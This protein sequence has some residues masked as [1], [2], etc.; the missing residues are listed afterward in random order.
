MMK[1][2][3]LQLLTVLRAMPR[4]HKFILA[5]L[6]IGLTGSLIGIFAAS[7]GHASFA[8]SVLTR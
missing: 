2:L 7:A 4:V 6:G 5:A 8:A 1:K 3:C